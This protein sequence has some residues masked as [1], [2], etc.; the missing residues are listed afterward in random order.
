MTTRVSDLII[1]ASLESTLQSRS[2]R[3]N[4]ALREHE[5]VELS[6]RNVHPEEEFLFQIIKV[7]QME[8]QSP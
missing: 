3:L 5:A 1:K 8:V 2:T 6:Q 4:Y 7:L